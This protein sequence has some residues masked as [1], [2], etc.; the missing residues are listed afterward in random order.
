ML[1]NEREELAKVSIKHPV[2]KMEAELRSGTVTIPVDGNNLGTVYY[3]CRFL[4]GWVKLYDDEE[5]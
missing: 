5:G 1:F 2:G 4:S 3:H